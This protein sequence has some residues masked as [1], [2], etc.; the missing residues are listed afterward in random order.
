MHYF[1]RSKRLADV[2]RLLL[3]V[4]GIEPHPGPTCKH[5][6]CKRDGKYVL[7]G[8]EYCQYHHPVL[9]KRPPTSDKCT[10]MN[11]TKS[12]CKEQIVGKVGDRQIRLSGLAPFVTAGW[13]VATF[14]FGG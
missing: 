10:G 1:E 11:S 2:T 5:G 12:Q 4:A 3:L 9:S 13:A 7:L 8:S 6:S 14:V